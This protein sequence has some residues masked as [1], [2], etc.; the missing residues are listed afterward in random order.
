M[1]LSP[2]IPARRRRRWPV[3]A[4]GPALADAAPDLPSASIGKPDA[5]VTVME[6]FSLTCTHCAA[7]HQKRCREMN[8]S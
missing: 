5:K 8:E 4:P 2:P 1:P 7:F 3:P 6:F